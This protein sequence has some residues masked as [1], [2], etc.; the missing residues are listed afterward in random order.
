M[1][2]IADLNTPEAVAVAESFFFFFFL[3]GK[4]N[5][6]LKRAEP[7]T[8]TPREYT[9]SIQRARI[10]H[11]RKTKKKKT[12]NPPLKLLRTQHSS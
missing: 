9:R 2:T 1:L 6:I 3:I 10:R 7:Q 11:K 12:T 8:G 5:N 4:E